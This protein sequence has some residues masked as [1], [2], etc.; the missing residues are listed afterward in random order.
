[1]GRVM[2]LENLEG[3]VWNDGIDGKRRHDDVGAL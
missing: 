3:V 1:M 2:R